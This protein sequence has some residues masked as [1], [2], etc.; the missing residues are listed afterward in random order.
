MQIKFNNLPVVKY[1][2]EVIF[3]INS[4]IFPLTSS[5]ESIKEADEKRLPLIS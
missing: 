1:A 4:N 3:Q 2:V 5:I